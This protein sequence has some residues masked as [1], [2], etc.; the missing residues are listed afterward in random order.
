MKFNVTSLLLFLLVAIQSFAQ[1]NDS[2]AS[3]YPKTFW[4]EGDMK[5][6]QFSTKELKL[7]GDNAPQ[8][9]EYTYKVDIS[10]SNV[11][12]NE[13]LIHWKFKDIKF[14][15]K[16]YLNNP[17]TLLDSLTITYKIDE[18]GRFLSYT[19]LD[20][21]IEQFLRSSEKVEN[22][23]L[24]KADSLQMIKKTI[25]A[26]ALPE[27]IVKIFDKDIKQFHLFFGKKIF[28][29]DGEPFV[30]QSYMDNLFSTSP[31]PA[32]TSLTL[33][34]INP[35]KTNYILSAFQ[36]ADKEWLANSWYTYLNDLAEKL[37]SEKPS[38]ERLKDEIT[39]Q[40][41]TNSRI[42]DNGWIL[43]SI[44]TKKVKFQDTV[45]TLEKKFELLP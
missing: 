6:Y 32:K 3:V 26:Y 22:L 7:D 39:Y 27:N 28:N 29:I 31:T 33:K 25:S 11:Y 45:F 4:N 42:K 23:Y 37:G 15:K 2:T 36:Q 13:Y 16:R 18:D 14:D 19:E 10:V 38:E 12:E 21:T 41:N 5:Q 43:Y 34:E 44:E 9:E 17:F 8:K 30:Y 35:S 40:V 24:D 20:N 1:I